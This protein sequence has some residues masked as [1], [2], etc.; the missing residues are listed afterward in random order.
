[1]NTL[2]QVSVVD[3]TQQ[4][5]KS[6]ESKNNILHRRSNQDRGGTLPPQWDL[7]FSENSLLS[8]YCFIK[9]FIGSQT[10]PEK[11]P[12]EVG[13]EVD[14]S[15]GRF[16]DLLKMCFFYEFVTAVPTGANTV[17]IDN[18]I[19]QA[20]DLVKSHLMFAVREEVEVLKEKITELL[21]RISQLEHENDI[22]RANASAETLKQLNSQS[23]KKSAS[24]GNTGKSPPVTA[25][26]P[27]ST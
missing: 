6:V 17:A 8:V 26:P 5:T 19:E 12:S 2:V 23:H 18:K 10:A 21:E 3:S 16:L 25:I 15:G 1:M 4:Q 14:P 27:S 13:Q 20:M 9:N 24:G 11:L 22:L 7:S